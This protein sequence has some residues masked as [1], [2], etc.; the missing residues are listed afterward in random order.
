MGLSFRAIQG[1]LYERFRSLLM[2][3]AFCMQ[4]TIEN[5]NT[6][7]QYYSL[8][9][10]LFN[11]IS[12]NFKS[13]KSLTE[14]EFF[15]IIIWKSNRSKTKVLKGILK[16]KKSIEE[17]TNDIFKTKDDKE[18]LALLTD[19]DGIGIP[20]A[21]AVLSVCFPKDFTIADYRAVDSI[22]DI[23][24]EEEINPDNWTPEKY[25]EYRG[26]CLAIQKQFNLG[27]LR[28]TDK[29]LWGYSFYRDLQNLVDSLKNTKNSGSTKIC[30]CDEPLCAKCLAVNC[31]DENCITHTQENKD[32]WKRRHEGGNADNSVVHNQSRT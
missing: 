31:T 10:Y 4:K 3:W 15:S 12:E 7:E 11:E 23:Y 17:L 24:N 8:E 26:W 18:R 20:I 5:L 1:N 28:E 27:T 22:K 14:Q 9:E 2:W 19:I 13:N 6:Y 21:S 16:S 30:L 25:F 32:R 29:V